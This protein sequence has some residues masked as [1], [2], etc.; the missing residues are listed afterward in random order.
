MASPF[1]QILPS[2]RVQCRELLVACRRSKTRAC[3]NVALHRSERPVSRQLHQLG[4][5]QACTTR[6]DIQ[7]K[8]Q[9]CE[10][11]AHGMLIECISTRSP[12]YALQ[13]NGKFN[14]A[15]FRG[16][17]YALDIAR[18]NRIKACLP[19]PSSHNCCM[20]AWGHVLHFYMRMWQSRSQTTSAIL[21]F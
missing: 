7:R 20:R 14:E 1:I 19:N 2:S 11:C 3:S 12:Q 21:I 13:D 16:L 4:D 6:A 8:A 17:D 5:R 9:S 10:Y 15:I 18:Q